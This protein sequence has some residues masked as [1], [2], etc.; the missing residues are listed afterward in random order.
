MKELDIPVISV[1]LHLSVM[2]MASENING[3][4]EGGEAEV[5]I[6]LIFGIFLGWKSAYQKYLSS[7]SAFTMASLTI[8]SQHTTKIEIK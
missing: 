1:M 8:K 7:K 4:L 3:G 2:Q 5:S 6:Q